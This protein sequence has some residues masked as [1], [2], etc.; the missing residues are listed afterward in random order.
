[1]SRTLSA[2]ASYVEV[3]GRGG[4]LEQQEWQA[5]IASNKLAGRCRQSRIGGAGTSRG[6][7]LCSAVLG[8]V[9]CDSEAVAFDGGAVKREALELWFR[10]AHWRAPNMDPL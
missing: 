5:A 8:C 9:L 4:S 1:M 7:H 10:P 2:I 6:A 3:G